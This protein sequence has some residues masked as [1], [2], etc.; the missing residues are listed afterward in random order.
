MNKQADDAP[1]ATLAQAKPPGL[2]VHA[3]RLGSPTAGRGDNGLACFVASD[4]EGLDDV[5]SLIC[6]RRSTLRKTSGWDRKSRAKY[7]IP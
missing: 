7:P 6:Y 4:Q 3:V 1:T 2:P 5:N